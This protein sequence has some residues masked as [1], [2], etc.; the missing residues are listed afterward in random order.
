MNTTNKMEQK[1][2]YEISRHHAWAGSVLL[3][4]LLAIRIFFETSETTIDNTIF[5]AIGIIIV[6]Y[7]LIALIL[8]YKY[9]SGITTQQ[10]IIQKTDTKPEFKRAKDAIKIEK[11]K[12]KAEAKIAKKQQK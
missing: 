5:I 6:L 3:A 7:I 9:R 10:R 11:K 2:R 1:R 12:A 4:V 8:T